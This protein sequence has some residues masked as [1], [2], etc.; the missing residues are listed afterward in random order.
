M[1]RRKKWA[2]FGL[3]LL[4][5]SAL[6]NPVSVRATNM[7]TSD[8]SDIMA[9][10]DTDIAI[11][12]VKM[13]GQQAGE[14]V[15]VSFQAGID[16]SNRN[17]KVMNI[18]KI[19]PVLDESFPFETDNEAYKVINAS[20]ASVDASYSFTAKENLET[21]YYPVAFSITYDRQA[22]DGTVTTYY[23]IKSISVKIQAKE[24]SESSD[25][26]ISLKVKSAPSG[27]YGKTCNVTFQTKAKKGK[28]LS[29]TPVVT[30]GFPFETEKDAYRSITSKGTASLKCDYTF[31][32]REDVM[33]GYQMVS[34]LVKYQKDGKTYEV[35]RSLNVKLTGKKSDSQN[36][37]GGTG[38]TSTPRLMVAGY[39][40]GK[41]TIYA[42]ESFT[43]TLHME[44][45][46]KS[47]ISN[48]KLSL[49]SE[50]SQFVPEDGVGSK[51]I[52]SMGAGE[53][54]DITFQIKPLSGLE[55]KSYP[56]VIKSE[57]ENGKA[58]AFSAEDTLYVPVYLRQRLSITDVYLTQD[59]YEVGDMVEVSA[60]VNNLG[61]GN[62]YNV[63][64]Y[65]SGDNVEENS[66]YV[67]NVEPGKSG[68]A[69]ILAKATV[70]T[71]GAY[72][73][74]QML[75]TYEDKDGNVQEESVKIDLH[76]NEPVY[77]NLEK[78]KTSKDS[79]DIV[80]KIGSGVIAVVLIAGIGYVV[81]RRRKRK[82]QILDE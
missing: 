72:T 74:N 77:D 53:K 15:T 75:I 3:C 36:G 11:S 30:D 63:T 21:G 25:G 49:G 20:G 82:Q 65:L 71:D 8:T 39:D 19:V 57:Y 48:I 51:F 76:V 10:T 9:G 41:D 67:G 81:F 60:T 56:L 61:E 43:L 46:A 17:Y 16:N 68:T 7:E 6:W 2:A 44:N 59:S 66:S 78:V 32:V 37:S 64:V 54:L 1:S 45:T 40:L 38:N 34:F 28:I 50:E 14:K 69:D 58:E 5:V 79:S 24:E 55:E 4:L 26:D 35:T 70:V 47:T 52:E 13:D 33:T 73:K 31:K 22:E 80:K 18:T 23:V 27:T 12:K 42:N 62:L 29:V